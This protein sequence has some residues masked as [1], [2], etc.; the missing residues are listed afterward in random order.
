V[1][2]ETHGAAARAVAPGLTREALEAA[3]AGERQALLEAYLVERAAQVLGVD[4]A[5]VDREQPLVGQ[6]MDSLRAME[7]KGALEAS[8]GAAVPVSAL[9]DDAGIERLAADLLQAMFLADAA[10][11]ALPAAAEDDAPLSFAQER[12]WFL[13][14]LQ[15]GSA[16]YN[17]AGALRLRGALDAA[18]LRRSLAATTRRHEA[19]RTVFAESGGRPV[20]RV[21]AAADPP[22]PGADLSRLDPAGREAAA[23]RAAEAVARAPFDLAVGP[24]FRARLLRLGSDEHLLVLAMHHVVGDGWST[25]VVLRELAALYGALAAGAPSPLAPLRARYADF[26]AAERERLRGEAVDAEVEYWR[27]RLA[28]LAPLELPTTHPRPAA[29]SFRGATH[30]F[31]VPAE[32]AAGLAALGRAEGAT[33]HMTLL[34]AFAA[35]L[36]RYSGAEDVAVGSPVANRDT[37]EARALVGLFVNTVVLRVDLSGDPPF[38]ELLRRVRATSLEAYAHGGLPFEKLVEAI[39]PARDLGRNP[40]FQVMFALQD[41]AADPG[42]AAGVSLELEPVDTGTSKLD[43]T[44]FLAQER[45]GALSAALEYAT[46]LFDPRAA[47][48]LAGHYGELLASAARDPANRVSGL[49]LLTPGE[50]ARVLA[51]WN[52]TRRA[53]PAACVHDLFTAQAARM[54]DAVAVRSAGDTL[55]YAGLER[56]S[57]ALARLLR[58]RGV[59]PEVRVGVCLERGTGLLVGLLGVL[60][61]GG[62][63]VPLDPSYPRERLAYVLDDARVPVLLTEA[64]LAAALPAH[65]ADVVL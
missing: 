1:R 46:D 36:A 56:R 34:A 55:S 19:L 61:A 2:E 10:V 43:L 5:R 12:L 42:R 37:E 14:R 21:P 9:L 50:R 28:G 29:Q 54:P 18:A 15:P 25:G 45:D 38:R 51:E 3:E 53:V 39:R 63:Y 6:G 8:L 57:A 33:L 31:R 27:G 16:A 35:L 60:R 40:L 26:A 52:D 58:A 23:R 22:L 32:V 41:R 62:A 17:L 7:L 59:G 30:R 11:P 47:A 4:P 48:A 20:Q 64:A 24:P 44:L 49:G 65:R 13:D